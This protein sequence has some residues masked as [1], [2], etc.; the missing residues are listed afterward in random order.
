MSSSYQGS[1]QTADV[2][3]INKVDS[4]D[5]GGHEVEKNIK[6]VNPKATIIKAESKNNQRPDIIKDKRV[7]IVEDRHTYPWWNGYR[8]DDCS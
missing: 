3:I 5:K 7:L 1:E 8:W 4:A 6:R 2:A